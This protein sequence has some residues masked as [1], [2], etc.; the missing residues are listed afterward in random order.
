MQRIAFCLALSAGVFAAGAC[1]AADAKRPS[2]PAVP[3]GVA[4]EPNVEYSNPDNQHLQLDIA[5]P[6]KGDGLFPAILCIHGGGFRAGDRQGYDKLCIR[7]AEN[8]Y[9]AATVTYRLAP[10]Y[11]FPDAI[12]DCKAAVRWLRANAAKY[13]IDPARIGVTG[14]SAGGHL[15]Q[16]LGVT[17][18][19]KEFEGDG[20]N[21]TQSSSVACVVN[22]YGPSDFTKSY[23][24]SKDAAEVLPLWLGGDLEKAH[25]RHI[26]A[27]PLYWVTPNAAPTL[28]IQGTKDNYVAYEQATW[29]VDK[30]KA[31]DVEAELM[32]MEGA[33]HGFQGKDAEKADAA[34]I[35]FFDKHLKPQ[36]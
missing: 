26:E 11:Q 27:S 28:D 33:G 35:A 22:Y 2:G 14:G 5:R 21:P 10:K 15:A 29:M 1:R 36:R 20:G 4:F 34:M 12:Y 3:E 18:G 9:V 24:H 32:T 6:A 30:L 25:R 31:A 23:G 8:G 7:L 19:V 13:H 16:F 17:N